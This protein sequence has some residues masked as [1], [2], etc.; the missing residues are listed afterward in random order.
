M[1]KPCLLALCGSTRAGSFN[2]KIL[3]L[4]AHGAEDAGARVT[5]VDL[6][7]YPLPLYEGDLE[8]DRGLPPTAA[9]LQTLFADHQGLLLASPEYNGFFTPLVK[10]TLDWVSRP[11]PDGSDR[12]GT[13]HCQN[14][15]AGIASASPGAFG[16]IR[17]LQHTRLYLANLGFLVVADQVGV[18]RAGQ[19]F[20]DQGHL[21]DRELHRRTRDI[22][23]SV[24]RLAATLQGDKAAGMRR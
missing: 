1:E 9:A 18:A 17:S 22:G 10:N 14:M 21:V 19:A 8:A 23:A 4:M 16:G 15:P 11:L 6:R 12:P 3:H 20:D 24:A 5:H 13:V 2:N 7:A